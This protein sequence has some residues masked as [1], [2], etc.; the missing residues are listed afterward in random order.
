M[1]LLLGQARK[2]AA[3]ISLSY[4]VRRTV[5]ANT[6]M[7]DANIVVVGSAFG[8]VDAE[9]GH[10]DGTIELALPVSPQHC[11]C[12]ARGSTRSLSRRSICPGIMILNTLHL[13][14]VPITCRE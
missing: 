12:P 14:L 9:K 2:P 6:I 8:L 11:C 5:F 1:K 7:A 3:T 4:L 10:A 13:G